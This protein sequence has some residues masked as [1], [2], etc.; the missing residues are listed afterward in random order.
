[1]IAS[2]PFPDVSPTLVSVDIPLWQFSLA[3]MDFGLG[4]FELALRW[5]ALAYI[6][7]ILLASWVMRRALRRPV[8]WP[9][10]RPAFSESN[11]DDLITWLIFGIIIGGRLG[12]V[13]F[14]NPSYYLANPAAAL[15]IFDGGMSFHGGFLG[16]VAAGLLFCR[17]HKIPLLKASDV[18]AAS[19]PAGLLFGRLANFINAELWG[20][21]TTLPWGVIFPGVDAQTCVEAATGLCA[22]H[23]SQLYEALGEGLI[24][25]AVL[26]YLLFRTGALRRSGLLTGIFLTG[27]GL[28]RFMVEWVRQPDAQFQTMDNPIGYAVQL[29]PT[30]LTM[31]QI[32]TLP[33]LLAGLW[34]IQ[35]A[36]AKQ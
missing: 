12:Y 9:Q 4:G 1:M 20:R 28:T 6:A 29:G 16:V 27:Y 15:R 32:L 13:L 19:A 2:I 11:L 21:E 18:M 8:L 36:R 24:L 34:L 14:Y 3:G 10:E 22:R 35:K 23:P 25:G 30:G 17:K 26:L 5:Y 31:G 33:M 7:G